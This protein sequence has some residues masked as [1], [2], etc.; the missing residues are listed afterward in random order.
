MVPPD[1]IPWFCS[2]CTNPRHQ[3]ASESS[4]TGV[5]AARGT[6]S[7]SNASHTDYALR[8]HARAQAPSLNKIFHSSAPHTK[9]RYKKRH[10]PTVRSYLELEHMPLP[11]WHE[12]D[13]EAE[14]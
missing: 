9:R 12:S 4:D 2:E 1:G 6:R 14:P 8:T 13:H 5:V 10:K 3:K 7:S 11:T